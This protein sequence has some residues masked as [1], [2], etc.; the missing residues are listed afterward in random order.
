MSRISL[1]LACVLTVAA[2]VLGSWSLVSTKNASW[3]FFAKALHLESIS[4]GSDQ[5]G[6]TL[7][8]EVLKRTEH[9]RRAYVWTRSTPIQNAPGIQLLPP[10]RVE[11]R[12]LSVSL[13]HRTEKRFLL[14]VSPLHVAACAP[15]DQLWR[16]YAHEDKSDGSTPFPLTQ[17]QPIEL[18]LEVDDTSVVVLSDFR[19]NIIR[20]SELVE[21]V[22][23]FGLLST[24]LPG[25]AISVGANPIQVFTLGMQPPSPSTRTG[26]AI[27]VLLRAADYDHVRVDDR[28]Q[29]WNW[30]WSWP[31]ITTLSLFLIAL[32]QLLVSFA[33]LSP[34]AK[35]TQAPAEP[36]REGSP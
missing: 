9:I 6:F 20:S 1:V 33:Q 28:E 27:G 16:G 7:S 31:A 21:S 23:A 12:N 8:P 2:A 17:H 22:N 35:P 30:L 19:A 32:A 14:V 15:Q 4:M 5:M 24:P 18:E 13:R 11:C 26:A 25:K 34:S 3:G 36:Q 29:R 10:K